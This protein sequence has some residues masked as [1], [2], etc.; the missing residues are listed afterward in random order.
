MLSRVDPEPILTVRTHA[1]RVEA[2]RLTMYRAKRAELVRDNAIAEAHAQYDAQLRAIA[3]RDRPS[4]NALRRGFAANYLP[5]KWRRDQARWN[6]PAIALSHPFAS[7]L[8]PYPGVSAPSWMV[9][10]ANLLQRFGYRPAPR[11]WL[12]RNRG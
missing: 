11:Y 4:T 2:S 10:P 1:P 9:D 5:W 6:E 12:E 3:S 8:D 7:E